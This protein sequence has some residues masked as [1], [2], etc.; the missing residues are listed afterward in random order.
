[1][2]AEIIDNFHPKVAKDIDAR[3]K[4]ST[5]A[6]LNSGIIFLGMRRM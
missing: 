3:Y 1:M 5:Y 4:V 6:D 2:A